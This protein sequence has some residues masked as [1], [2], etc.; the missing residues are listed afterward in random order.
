MLHQTKPSVQRF[1]VEHANILQDAVLFGSLSVSHVITSTFEL[2]DIETFDC[3]RRRNGD[4]TPV[5]SALHRGMPLRN[6]EDN[7][8]GTLEAMHPDG[9]KCFL[10]TTNA[11]MLVHHSKVVPRMCLAVH[12]TI[13]SID[14]LANVHGCKLASFG[15]RTFAV[16]S[17]SPELDATSDAMVDAMDVV[18]GAL[19]TA[20]AA[21]CTTPNAA[22]KRTVR[23]LGNGRPVDDW[24]VDVGVADR[25]YLAGLPWTTTSTA[26]HVTSNKSSI[27]AFPAT[28]RSA[29]NPLLG[30][31]YVYP[32]RS[33]THAMY[34]VKKQVGGV[35]REFATVGD[36]QVGNLLMAALRVD[37]RLHSKRSATAWLEWMSTGPDT[38]SASAMWLNDVS[39]RLSTLTQ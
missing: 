20:A 18:G 1:T 32:A 15:D 21:P 2:V 22:A 37:T 25:A 13:D 33:Y 4:A 11:I 9:D 39:L 30:N 8:Y 36:A 34:V 31:S 24:F 12:D 26:M 23:R 5:P 19:V 7:S 27:D 28:L 14:H 6:L 3:L 10:R 29:L 17:D 35:M 38:T 16:P